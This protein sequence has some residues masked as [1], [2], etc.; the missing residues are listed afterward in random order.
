MNVLRL[1][2]TGGIATGKSTVGRMLRERGAFVVDSD[3]LA[4]AAMEPGGEAYP[5]IVRRFGRDILDADGRVDRKRLGSVVFRDPQA[6]ADLEAIVHPVVR[7][8]GDERIAAWAAGAPAPRIAFVDAALLVETG[9][10]RDLDGLVVVHC[11]PE[12]QLRRI[13][14]RDGLAEEEAR[15]RIAAQAPPERKLAAADWT[16]DTDGTLDDTER[17]AAEV[18]EAAVALWRRRFGEPDR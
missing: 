7:R 17:R 15:R 4:H 11:A 3:R 14:E 9:R 16:I 1:G 10:H 8:L 2:L 18:W 12:T 13:L 5:A 6:R